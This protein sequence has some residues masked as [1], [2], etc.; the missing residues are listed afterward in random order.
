[1]NTLGKT[2]VILNFLFAVVVGFLL[3]AD[4]ALRT[5]WK[6]AH[7]SLVREMKVVEES[8]EAMKRAVAQILA[9]YKEKQVQIENLT[10]E[11]KDNEVKRAAKEAE[12]EFKL[13]EF[14]NIASSKT[15]IVKD[16]EATLQRKTDEIA[17]LNSTI[18]SREE[19]IVRLEDESKKLRIT[20]VSYEAMYRAGKIQTENMQ[21]QLQ[22][23]TQ[24]L[25]KKEAG[26][27]NADVMSIRNPNEPNPPSVL[28]NGKVERVEGELVQLSVGTDHGVQKNHTLDVYRL[29]PEAKYLGMV[30]IVEANHHQSVGRLIASGNAAYRTPLRPGDHVTSKLTR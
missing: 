1:M 29:T 28:V 30:R 3:V 26:I 10:L 12:F 17:L 20:A 13:K 19:S 25:H 22:E 6:A 4:M 11:I 24:A 7:D 27:A 5:Q 9:D 14:E 2:L 23:V 16:L 21:A 15:L 18:K 8:R